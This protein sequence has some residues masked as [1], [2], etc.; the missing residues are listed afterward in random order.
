MAPKHSPVS[1]AID[2]DSY[3]R[4]MRITCKRTPDNTLFSFFFFRDRFCWGLEPLLLLLIV[5]E[6]HRCM[7]A[8]TKRTH[9]YCR[10]HVAVDSCFVLLQPYTHWVAKALYVWC[11]F[12]CTNAPAFYGHA[13]VSV[14]VSV[15]YEQP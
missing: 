11:L 7:R 6:R 4:L 8:V 3:F 12:L 14:S 2:G 10:N 5:H 1:L 15:V 9:H 13:V